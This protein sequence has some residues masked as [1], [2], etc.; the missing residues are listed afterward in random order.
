MAES[1]PHPEVAMIRKLAA[2]AFF[3]TLALAASA[4]SAVH[5][6]FSSDVNISIDVVAHSS[7]FSFLNDAKKFSL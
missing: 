7:N 5:F 6:S 4:A 1:P 3:L 2:L